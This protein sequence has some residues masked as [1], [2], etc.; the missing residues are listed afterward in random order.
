MFQSLHSRGCV[1]LYPRVAEFNL[2]WFT[3]KAALRGICSNY[4]RAAFPV[5][6]GLRLFFG[7]PRPQK[8]NYKDVVKV[9]GQQTSHSL[10]AFPLGFQDSRSRVHLS[11]KYYQIKNQMKILSNRPSTSQIEADEITQFPDRN[12]DFSRLRTIVY[13]APLQPT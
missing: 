13:W 6:A 9:G 12:V 8:K 2:I 1:D 11:P 7:F 5:I 10:C 4:R 3:G